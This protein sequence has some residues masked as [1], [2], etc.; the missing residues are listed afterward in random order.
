FGEPDIRQER[1]ATLVDR[2]A[3][4]PCT[5]PGIDRIE[6]RDAEIVDEVQ[7][8]ERLWQLKAAGEA[9]PHALIGRH[10]IDP[11]SV[12]CD[13][14]AVVMQCAGEAV[15][16]GALTRAIGPDQPEPLAGL[17]SDVDVLERDK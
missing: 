10:P 4:E 8:A 16:E 1:A 9:E 7:A 6:E 11:A 17:D 3:G 12:E 15:D 5:V 13:A 14:A 2:G